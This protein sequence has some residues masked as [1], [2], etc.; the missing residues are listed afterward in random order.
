[1]F[2]LGLLEAPWPSLHLP[3]FLIASGSPSLLIAK[4]CW[5]AW[6]P[7]LSAAVVCMQV[8]GVCAHTPDDHHV[9]ETQGRKENCP[10]KLLAHLGCPMP[11]AD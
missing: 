9:G 11:P 3:M 5:E 4:V 8:P 10:Q 2:H 7:I 1:M 6:G